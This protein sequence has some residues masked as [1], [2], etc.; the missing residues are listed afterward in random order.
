MNKYVSE[1]HTKKRTSLKMDKAQAMLEVKMHE[2]FKKVQQKSARNVG[3]QQAPRACRSQSGATFL[4][5]V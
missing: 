3:V 5:T 4:P 2:I 1:I